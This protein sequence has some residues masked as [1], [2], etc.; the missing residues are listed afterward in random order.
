MASSEDK[1]VAN[2]TKHVKILIV[3]AGMAG[4]NAANILIKCGITDLKILEARNR[5]GGRIVS[6]NMERHKVELGA[7]CIHGVLGNPTYELAI[8]NGLV[9]IVQNPKPHNVVA[10]TEEGRRVPFHILEEMFEV[11]GCFLHRCEEYFISQYAP[12]EGINSVG[13]H[14]AL[15]AA[16]YLEKIPNIEERRIRQA[17]FD[18]LLKRETCISGCHSMDEIDLIQ[19]GSYVELQ[20]GNISI[21]SGYSSILRPVLSVI[22]EDKILKRHVVSKICWKGQ[23]PFISNGEIS[24]TGSENSLL[25]LSNCPDPVAEDS[26][27]SDKTVTGEN[28]QSS[29]D[30]SP[31]RIECENGVAFT[32][33]HV[34]VTIP[35]GVLK[36]KHISLFEP[37]LPHSKCK[38]LERLYFGTVDKILLEYDRP[39]LNP[40]ITEVLL[41]WNNEDELETFGSTSGSHTDIADMSHRWFRKIYSFSKISE[42]LLL[43]FIS[44]KEAEY[45]ETLPFDRVAEK[46]TEILRKFL[47]DPFVPR[48][49]ITSWKN[50]KFTQG[51]YTSIAVGATQT[52]IEILAEPLYSD[53]LQTV[54]KVLFAGEH[55]H[56]SFYSTVHGAYL[57]GQRVAQALKKV[58]LHTDE[59]S[60]KRTGFRLENGVMKFKKQEDEENASILSSWVEG[61]SLE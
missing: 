2:I 8:A 57:S 46:C 20:G 50:Q 59:D 9:D 45:M 53:A 38:A 17:M 25:G 10:A 7:N 34:I 61:I 1:E 31:V 28:L 14:I 47:N 35:L 4:L 24:S 6:V 36:D 60:G 30:G 48:P 49:K 18:C 58:L 39:F 51:S 11:Y 26:D 41:L 55:T 44:G 3:G 16:I 12:P 56:P 22:P 37:T 27:D 54:P 13:E 29:N 21:P 40:D 42:T 5:V 52:D 19:L 32:A 43:G 15:E 23:Q 33:D